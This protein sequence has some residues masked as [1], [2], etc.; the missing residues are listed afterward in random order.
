MSIINEWHN[1]HRELTRVELSPGRSRG[2]SG[3]PITTSMNMSTALYNLHG[4]DI[5]TLTCSSL[6]CGGSYQCLHRLV[7]RP[8]SALAGGRL[9]CTS[10][11]PPAVVQTQGDMSHISE[12]TCRSTMLFS[13]CM[14]Y[15]AFD[16][17]DE[18]NMDEFRWMKEWRQQVHVVQMMCFTV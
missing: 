13:W 16:L 7:D 5:W 9:V 10:S 11:A 14:S 18:S 4:D 1:R 17:I 15:T 3:R 6:C 12:Y 8:L 2:R